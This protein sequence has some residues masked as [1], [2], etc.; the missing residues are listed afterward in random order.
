[1]QK[2]SHEPVYAPPAC[3]LGRLRPQDEEFSPIRGDDATIFSG[4]KDHIFVKYVDD[5]PDRSI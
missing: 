3:V 1:M 5:S 2:P 4:V